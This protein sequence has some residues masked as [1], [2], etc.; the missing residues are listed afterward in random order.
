M[1]PMKKNQGFSLIEVLVTLVLTV[2]GVLGMVAMQTKAIQY[3]NDSVTRTKAVLAVDDLIEILRSNRDKVY[4]GKNTLKADSEYFKAAAEDFT[5]LTCDTYSGFAGADTPEQQLCVW[6]KFAQASLPG[7]TNDVLKN[8][9]TI[10]PTI[11]EVDTINKIEISI[12][13]AVKVGE[14]LD[15]PEAELCSYTVAVE[16]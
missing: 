12:A 6:A 10:V 8:D 7:V 4:D 14:C 11:N 9:F 5:D 16:I 1:L 13:W 15:A 2:V 3:T